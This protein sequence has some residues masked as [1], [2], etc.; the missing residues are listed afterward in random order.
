LLYEEPVL[1]RLLLIRHG[2]TNLQN[3]D[4]YWGSTDIPLS[5]E[6]IRQAKQISARLSGEKITHIYSSTLSRARDT[7]KTTAEAHHKTITACAELNEFNF[8]YAEGLTYKEIEKQHPS[9]AKELARMGDITFPG[10]ESL[11]KFFIRTQSFLKRL[12]KHQSQDV[13]A[14]VAHAGSL[15]MLICHLLELDQHYWYKLFIDYASLSIV[16]TYQHISIISA[17]N[18][19]SH[20]KL[21]ET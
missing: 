16:D 21:K 12:E 13:I 9:L 11:D 15:R 20:L 7:A 6:G 10:G 18:D 1:A 14:V 5:D 4:R 19:T 3:E 17:L 8:G 2:R